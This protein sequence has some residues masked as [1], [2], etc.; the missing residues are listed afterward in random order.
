M[1]DFVDRIEDHFQNEIED[2]LTLQR[3]VIENELANALFSLF[4]KIIRREIDDEYNSLA[5]LCMRYREIA[6]LY[7]QQSTILQQR[8]AWFVSHLSEFNPEQDPD[9]VYI[10]LADVFEEQGFALGVIPDVDDALTDAE[11]TQAYNAF[12]RGPFFRRL[13]S[14]FMRHVL[15]NP[16]D[17]AEYLGPPGD[18]PKRRTR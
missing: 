10:N 11:A 16:R 9:E 2:R 7:G 4:Q 18:D 6:R 17:Y 14:D 13:W 15:E 3:N 1:E 8:R 12:I 5:K